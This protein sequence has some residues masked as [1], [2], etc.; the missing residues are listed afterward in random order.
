MIRSKRF[1]KRQNLFA[2]EFHSMIKDV[3]LALEV[4]TSFGNSMPATGFSMEFSTWKPRL[5]T[6]NQTDLS[7]PSGQTSRYAK[8]SSGKGYISLQQLALNTFKHVI[9]QI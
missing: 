4:K 8:T 1:F 5:P 6:N 3:H 7:Q 9:R 2:E